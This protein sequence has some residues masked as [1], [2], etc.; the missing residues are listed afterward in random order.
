MARPESPLGAEWDGLQAFAADLRALRVSAGNPPYRELGKRA[1]YSA[2]ALSEAANGRKLP[3]LAV[4]VAYVVACGGNR[5]E[6][7]SRWRSLATEM[8]AEKPVEFE[9]NAPYIGLTAF[10][11]ADADRFFGRERLVGELVDLTWRRRFVGVFG[12]SGSGKSSVL[13]AGLVPRAER[14]V[15]CTPGPHPV[16][17][18]AGA[19]AGLTG[20]PAAALAAEFAAYPD[21]LHVRV[22]HALGEADQDLLLVVDQFEEVFTLCHDPIERAAF[23][24]LLT[25][26]AA[27]PTS[28]L[29][30]VIGVRTDFTGHCGQHPDLV[31]ALRANQVLVGRMTTEELRRAITEPAVA[32]GCKVE[33]ALVTRLVAD[34]AGQ[35]A[36]LPLLSHALLETWR[37]RRGVALTLAAYESVGGIEHAIARTAERVHLDLDPARQDAARRLFLRLIAVGEGTEDTKRRL[38]RRELADLDT[39]DVVDRLAD[40]RL[41]AL[42]ED[43]VEL[44][45]EALI[46][47]WPRL[48]VWIDADRDGLRTQRRLTE[49]AETWESLDRDPGALYRGTRLAL[50]RDG[51]RAALTPRE[52]AFLDAGVAAE[53]AVHDLDR[54]RT[55]R[56]R[57][58]VAL[59]AVLLLVAV[60]AVGYAFQA[61]R[62]AT[63]QRN[64]ALARKAISEAAAIH[65]TNPALSVQL[66][67]AAYRLA[68]AADTRSGLLGAFVKP[69]ADRFDDVRLAATNPARGLVVGVDQG[70]P[71]LW[72]V[73]DPRHP[74][75]RS[76]LDG[77]GIT[78]LTA[79]FSPDGTLLA[80]HT[81]SR[82]VL[83]W[84][85]RDPGAPQR[86]GELSR[87]SSVAA[88][89]FDREGTQVVVADLLEGPTVWDVADPV[90]PKKRANLPVGESYATAFVSSDVVVA[91]VPSPPRALVWDV[92]SA[93]VP[94]VLPL[95]AA[96]YSVNSVAVSPDGRTVAIASGR[97]VGLWDFA[98]VRNPRRITTVDK[99]A[100]SVTAAAF[101]PDGRTLAIASLDH[102]TY[103]WNVADP[104][105]P[106]E[107][108]RLAGHLA[109][110]SLVAFDHG[111]RTL[112]TASALGAR[113]THLDDLA[114]V[115]RPRTTAAAVDPV[116]R[117]AAVVDEDGGLRLVDLAGPERFGPGHPLTGVGAPVR[118]AAFSRNGEFLVVALNPGNSGALR[119]LS[120]DPVSTLQVWRVTDPSAPVLVHDIVEYQSTV[121]SIAFSPAGDLM[122]TSGYDG[123]IRLWT[124]AALFGAGDPVVPPAVP[125]QADPAPVAFDGN[126]ALLT[127]AADGTT[128]LRWD[129]ADP[130]D[131]KSIGPE[132]DGATAVLTL[133]TPG[134]LVIAEKSDGVVLRSP[135]GDV[136]L[137]EGRAKALS[138]QGGT[139]VVT[140]TDG[141][142]H[143]WDVA[144]VRA[145]RE[146]ARLIGHD[147]AVASTI[148]GVD[149][150]GL[151]TVGEDG[152]VRFW[153]TDPDRVA[154]RVC[155]TAYPRMTD[156]EWQHYFP[157]VAEDLP[158]G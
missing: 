120:L 16:T 119:T 39:A 35:P 5:A 102:T 130:A 98:D 14:A 48:R 9:G 142:V 90:R 89:A 37:R 110:I 56:L 105:Q 111:G 155:A 145:P 58:L 59:M 52:V 154:E 146:V 50:A 85:V 72:D 29:R 84:D 99:Q 95:D 36:V 65:D 60:T 131:P 148:P 31:Q 140:G 40:A 132:V 126:G 7:E 53:D 78:A 137:V 64:I 34:A 141:T 17:E 136:R 106:F 150:R 54:R 125:G 87:N 68:P 69:Y 152:A 115:T 1:N 116:R 139:V 71:T 19:L 6:W 21:N 10:Q 30:I 75:R 33:T 149:E 11:P 100:D 57:R 62:A 118:V 73:T 153:D 91:V 114:A 151:V 41:V 103:L 12:A 49:D 44:A 122:A 24:A 129:V 117:I 67:L 112:V 94:T 79:A 26:A 144:D 101:G 47:N 123:R 109:A 135:S 55:R 133:P 138:R 121:A 63:E 38:G 127:V 43:G 92:T 28:R 124:S 88:M 81:N 70:V 23:I 25:T 157:D 4:T 74:V 104:A 158:C 15:L 22:R 147:G 107:I 27:A 42:D 80:T 8:V 86:V 45:H 32:A 143:L 51:D 66:G 61:Q 18:L 93:D 134:Y 97:S 113:F 76:A 2:A 108:A 83:L 128:I 96:G 3:S 156:R 13:R 46:R 20:K 82:T 77:T